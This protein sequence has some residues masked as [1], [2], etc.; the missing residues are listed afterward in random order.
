[1]GS[2]MCIRDRR[3]TTVLSHCVCLLLQLQEQS[4]HYQNRVGL[5]LLLTKNEPSKPISEIQRS[6]GLPASWTHT[7]SK[8]LYENPSLIYVLF[9]QD[10]FGGQKKGQLVCV[11]PP[12]NTSVSPSNFKRW[13]ITFQLSIK[14][15]SHSRDYRKWSG[16]NPKIP[17]LQRYAMHEETASVHR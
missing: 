16:S 7:C 6:L 2:E 1:M 15:S 14:L 12:R 9:L 10:C 11:V 13:G 8:M 4:L 17:P 3:K 5:L